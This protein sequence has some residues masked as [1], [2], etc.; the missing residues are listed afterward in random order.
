MASLKMALGM[1]GLF[2]LTGCGA[3]VGAI[4]GTPQEHSKENADE[5]L[6]KNDP[7]ELE[8]MCKNP[9]QYKLL[10]EDK[11]RV[12]DVVAKREMEEVK[13][14]VAAASCDGLYEFHN[15][16]NGNRT[17]FGDD[18]MAQVS[19]LFVKRYVECKQEKALFTCG[20]G[21]IR[22]AALAAV[23]KSD[24]GA[25]SAAFK[26]FIESDGRKFDMDAC[27]DD[28]GYALDATFTFVKSMK[29]DNCADFVKAMSSEQALGR[30]ILTANALE[31]KKCAGAEK[32]V[33]DALTTDN[34]WFKEQACRY[35]GE[36]GTAD[37]ATLI[38]DVARAHTKTVL[39][40]GGEIVRP[41]HDVC[42]QAAAKI[43]IR[44]KK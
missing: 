19:T 18:D 5:A 13:K 31:P 22:T 1:G 33:A 23:D 16:Y 6:A 11:D 7:A 40:D 25:A 8:A 27:K 28:F 32:E 9:S 14:E 35:L 38:E 3:I 4:A 15:K 36:F 26:R 17:G 30:A 20:M 39:T 41:V 21:N 42:M 44:N 29:E 24:N 34:V 10:Q 12:C 37:Q 2:L 43:K